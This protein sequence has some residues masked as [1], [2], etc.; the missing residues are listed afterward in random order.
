MR[1]LAVVPQYSIGGDCAKTFGSS[2]QQPLMTAQMAVHFANEMRILGF[3]HAL[4]CSM[5]SSNAGRS[6]ERD[7]ALPHKTA[8]LSISPASV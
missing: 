1:D 7:P 2:L 5:A 8:A 6:I 3:A 4:S